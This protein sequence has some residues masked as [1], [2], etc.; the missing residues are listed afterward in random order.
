MSSPAAFRSQVAAVMEGFAQAA[1]S[2]IVRLVEEG[3]VD[4]RLEMCRRETEI[5]ELKTRVRI[6]ECELLKAQ[7]A[8]K[9]PGTQEEQERTRQHRNEKVEDEE[10]RALYTETE[11]TNPLCDLQDGMVQKHNI[12]PVMKQEP[13][14]ELEMMDNTI[15][16]DICVEARDQNDS[17]W[18]PPTYNMSEQSS[19]ALEKCTQMFLSLDQY[20][21]HQSTDG[22]CRSLSTATEN[23]TN[24]SAKIEA[25]TYPMCAKGTTAGSV[26][27]EMLRPSTVSQ[28]VCCQSTSQSLPSVQRSRVDTPGTNSDLTNSRNGFRIKRLVNMC[29]INQK[30]FFCSV[31]NKAF[32]RLSQLEKHKATHQPSKP[33][34]CLE[35]GKSFTQKTRLKTHQSVH[36]GE[37]P[38]SC[39]IC[40]K[41]FSR[42]DNCMRHERFHSGLR[43][44]SCRQC[45]KSFT[46]LGNLKMHQEIHLRGR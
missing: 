18:P 22:F 33:F 30:L 15:I 13:T 21:I 17:A 24:V 6:L 36:T 20:S 4:L 41:M 7:E 39:K 45:G 19:T 3:S 44:F 10:V 8:T 43:P 40:G 1:V 42:Q 28:D 2:E 16:A 14:D 31:C 26:H 9:P 32:H 37:R 34:R 29:R 35:C 25:E 11:M 12:S 27:T 23:V 38:F 5:R 46:M